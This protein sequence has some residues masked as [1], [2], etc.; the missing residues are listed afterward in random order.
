MRQ[1][2]CTEYGFSASTIETVPVEDDHFSKRWVLPDYVLHFILFYISG[3][4]SN[5]PLY[6]AT[7]FHGEMRSIPEGTEAKFKANYDDINL[8]VSSVPVLVAICRKAIKILHPIRRITLAK[9]NLSDLKSVGVSGVLSSRV[10]YIDVLF[11]L[12]TMLL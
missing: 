1:T 9:F 2:S 10:I 5:W 6:G 7:C 8:A 4:I 11:E 3:V 12:I